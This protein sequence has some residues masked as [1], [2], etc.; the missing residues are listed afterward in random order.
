VAQ[1]GDCAGVTIS[2]RGFAVTILS[3]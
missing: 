1:R 2:A 3:A